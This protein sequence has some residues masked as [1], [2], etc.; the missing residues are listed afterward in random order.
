M[1]QG[2]AQ[3]VGAAH[4]PIRKPTA[5]RCKA[6][7]VLRV[8]CGEDAH[9][10]AESIGV[11]L[12]D[13]ELWR[14]EF[15][16]AGERRMGELPLGWLE[17][18][19]SPFERLVPLAT[20]VSVAIA[21]ALFVQGRQHDREARDKE[22]AREREQRVTES[23][24][25]LDDKYIDYVKLCLQH[26]DLDVYDTPL[27][28]AAPLGPER[29]RQEA[30]MFAILLSVME[31]SY[32]MYRDQQDAFK[33]DE[34]HAWDTYIHR[35]AVRQNFADEWKRSRTEYDSAFQKYIDDL[36]SEKKPQSRPAP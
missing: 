7:A 15:V 3:K 17:R 21:V 24:N 5:G 13:V 1:E 11:P 27:P 25:A 20:L 8:M 33:S 6:E 31:R 18:C 28:H 36:L 10:V 35:W 14:R 26:P 22:A 29:K 16:L 30:M 32:L 9:E 19:L 2:T 34:W 4:H 23:F 12:H